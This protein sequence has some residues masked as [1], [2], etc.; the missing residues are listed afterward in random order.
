M[1]DA[2]G[3]AV[4]VYDEA[5]GR[6]TFARTADEVEGGRRGSVVDLAGVR[7]EGVVYSGFE[8]AP[9]VPWHGD[10]I[11]E[12]VFRDAVL[13]TSTAGW[14]KGQGDLRRVDGAGLLDLSRCADASGMFRDCR[15]LATLDVSWWA[16]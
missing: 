9:S 16:V 7:R 13:P 14:F 6:L 15:S 8:G 2:R 4:A 5:A 11:R 10:R 1:G 3:Q 12:V